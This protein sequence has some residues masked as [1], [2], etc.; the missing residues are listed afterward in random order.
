MM[1]TACL[2]CALMFS[3]PVVASTGE[4]E[5]ARF[6]ES[7][8]NFGFTSGAAHQCAESTTR[9]QIESDALKAF[10]GLVR[11]FGTDHAFMYAAA[12]GAGSAMQ[13]DRSKCPDYA[14]SF[15]K[16]MNR[17]RGDQ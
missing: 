12:F 13:I 14:A 8:R 7:V 11:L 3:A 1:K 4:D 2:L 6:E 9:P 17:H 16:S 10:S 5:D 15:S